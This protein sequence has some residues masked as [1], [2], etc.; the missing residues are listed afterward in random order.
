MKNKKVFLG[1]TCNG[2]TVLTSLKEVADFL[3]KSV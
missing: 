1:G 3:N 2:A